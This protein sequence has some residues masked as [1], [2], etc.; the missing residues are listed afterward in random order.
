M[1]SADNDSRPL[2][3]RIIPVGGVKHKP[4]LGIDANVPSVPEAPQAEVTKSSKARL[5]R[6]IGDLADNELVARPWPCPCKITGPTKADKTNSGSEPTPRQ[7]RRASES[8]HAQKREESQVLKSTFGRLLLLAEQLRDEPVAA[9][10]NFAVILAKAEGESERKQLCEVAEWLSREPEEAAKRVERLAQE[11][12]ERAS[13]E[14]RDRP[15]HNRARFLPETARGVGPRLAAMLFLLCHNTRSERAKGKRGK[16]C[17]WHQSVPWWASQIGVSDRQVRRLFASGKQMKLLDYES[18]GRGILAWTTHKRIFNEY[19]RCSNGWGFGLYWKPLA[20][21]LGIGGS[22][23]YALLKQPDEDGQRRKLH[24]DGIAY[25]LP[26]LTVRAVE[27]ECIRLWQV[28]A[29]R[30]KKYGGPWYGARYVY[31]YFWSPR[32]AE[33]RKKWQSQISSHKVATL[34]TERPPSAQD[35]TGRPQH[36]RPRHKMSSKWPFGA[37]NVLPKEPN[38]GAG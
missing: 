7:P 15:L 26:W 21:V 32:T 8:R 24:P 36:V 34:G 12:D 10:K 9:F 27:M 19:A 17:A 16:A 23:I 4:K 38:T 20:R 13:R 28:G 5:E 37:Q 29:L 14:A 25:R 30:R 18:T 22:A 33:D 3:T 2:V 35:V 6:D 11:M 31:T 1:E